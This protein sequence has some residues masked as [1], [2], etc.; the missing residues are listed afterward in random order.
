MDSGVI[1][2]FKAHIR[3]V[4]SRHLV[5]EFD[6][7]IAFHRTQGSVVPVKEVES[8]F[9]VDELT[10]INWAT[11]AWTHVSQP[12]IRNCWRHIGIVG[13]GYFDLVASFNSINLNH[14]SQA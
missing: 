4:Q 5:Q 6:K 13:E 2:C 12:T 8:V 3:R 7:L 14:P 10:A 11:E 1:A 9:A